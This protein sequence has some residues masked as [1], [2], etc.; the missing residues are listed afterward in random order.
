MQVGGYRRAGGR[1]LEG[2]GTV[3]RADCM[4][5]LGAAC[6]AGGILRERWQLV[7]ERCLRSLADSP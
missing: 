6:A 4:L 1:V 7:V 5:A 2:E 3:G